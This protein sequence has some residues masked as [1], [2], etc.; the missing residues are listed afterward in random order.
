MR[1]ARLAL[2]LIWLLGLPAGALAAQAWPLLGSE[3]VHPESTPPA[4]PA[5]ALWLQAAQDDVEGG[6]VALRSEGAVSVPATVGDLTGPSGVIPAT[7][8]RRFRVGYVPVSRPSTGVDRLDSAEYPDPLV[9]LDGPLVVP[10]GRTTGLYVQVT[11]PAGT[12]PGRYEAVIDLGPI[13]SLPLRVDVF[14]VRAG[15]DGFPVVARLEPLSLATALGVR[16]YDAR[17]VE[18]ILG[19]LLPMLRAHGVSPAKA[20]LTDPKI[21][22][23]WSADY[24]DRTDVG[25]GPVK[26]VG[27]NLDRFLGLGFGW[28]EAPFEVR[29]PAAA[30]EARDPGFTDPRRATLARSLAQALAGHGP[31]AFALPVDEPAPD[32]YPAVARA[33]RILHQHAP[34]VQVMVTEAPNPEARRVMAGA[35]DLWAP[36]V[37]DHYL[38]RDQLAAERAAGRG[39]WWYTYGSDTQRFTMNLLIDKPTTEA[40][41]SGWLAAEEG[42]QGMF[43]YS[44]NSWVKADARYQS[45][46]SEPWY[47]SHVKAEERCGGAPRPVGGNGEASLIYPSGDP[48]R[49]AFGSLRLEALRDGIEDHAVLGALRDRQP[50]YWQR[51]MD[52][53]SRA[54]SGPNEGF[55]SCKPT[56]R[57]PYLPVVATDPQDVMA[58]RY[59]A[60]LKLSGGRLARLSGRVVSG[61]RPVAGAVVRFGLFSTTTDAGGAW[62]LDEVPP[63]PGRLVISRDPEGLVDPMVIDVTDEQL[64]AGDGQVRVPAALPRRAERPVFA[65]ARELRLFRARRAPARARVKGRA[66]DIRISRRYLQNGR[67]PNG[68][69]IVAPEVEGWLP[70]GAAGRRARDW[71]GWRYLELDAAV[72]STGRADQPWR[73]VVTPG[74][75]RSARY[76]VIGQARQHLRLDLKG[77]PLRDVRYLRFGLE[78]ALPVQRRGGHTPTAELEISGMRL[79]R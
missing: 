12:A 77:L 26:L 3:K 69:R 53:L 43:Y 64:Q 33:G 71:R 24:R 1:I 21:D 20:P 18:G 5:P 39:T 23:G 59:A 52:G 35:V 42:V 8:V 29:V 67:E 47:L 30:G 63:L 60:L 73:L 7:A 48:R 36:P 75:W 34:G 37:W 15:R 74:N 11:V 10:A 41:V 2:A 31:R 22:A 54:Y 57:L 28:I 65:T 55:D 16:Q 17:L 62:V 38:H 61:G 78:S 68:G 32:Q 49:P 46:W 25:E 79:T 51:I 9:P 14:G 6:I 66:I 19:D 70:R 56:N 72:R 45:P 27:T 50:A 44:M 4:R 58:A 40:R 76:L 13:G